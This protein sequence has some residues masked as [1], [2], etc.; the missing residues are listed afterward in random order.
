MK[1]AKVVVVFF[2]AVAAFLAGLGYERW[3]GKPGGE[4]PASSKD[5]RRILYWVD[6]MHPAYK[7]DKPGIAP[8]CGMQLEPVYAGEAAP[9]PPGAERRI[10]Y[11]RDP[12]DHSYTSDKPGLNPETGNELEPVYEET[13]GRPPNA[14]Q[15]S[16]ERQQMIGVRYG[17]AE[18]STT[19][20]SFR[21]VGRVTIDETRIARVH[22]RVD[23]WIDK[24][25]VDFTGKEVRKGQALLTLYSPELLA[26]QREYLLALRAK[27]VLRTATLPSA[28]EQSE[29]L[30]EASRRRLELWDMSPEQID[31]VAR[32]GQPLTHV[33]IEAPVT[34]HVLSRNAFPG[35][36]ISPENELYV[37]A[38]LSRVWIMADVFEFDAPN[39]RLGQHA[40]VRLPYNSGARTFHATV[41]YIQP[42]LEAE[43]RTLKVRLETANPGLVLKPD[44]YV[45]VDFHMPRRER[46]M[47]P[48]EAVLDTGLRKTVFVDLGNGYLEPREVETGERAGDLIVIRSGLKPGER[49]VVSGN[50]LID[51]EAQLKS[52]IGNMGAPGHSHGEP[53]PGTGHKAPEVHRHD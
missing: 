27:N 30:L 31:E 8:D 48:A 35:Q 23:G 43:T 53:K 28:I 39:V 9:H 33:T 41:T 6:P 46:L 7:S 42:Q 2:V 34:G 20:D 1:A 19:S 24:V 52:A 50:F 44:M 22:T 40:L 18:V 25:F 17:T 11:Y 51:S 4:A 38:D 10:L 37:I 15:I 13:P 26:S 14:F 36:R 16:P 45:D 49:I 47:V 29:T 12:E 3:Y 32:T 21:T 5:G